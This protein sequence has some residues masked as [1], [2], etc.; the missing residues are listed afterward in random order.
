MRDDN[1]APLYSYDITFPIKSHW[2]KR[3]LLD[4]VKDS[5][6]YIIQGT[7]SSMIGVMASTKSKQGLD[8]SKHN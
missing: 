5:L 7:V 6:Q 2:I 8:I 4:P 1:S 3:N